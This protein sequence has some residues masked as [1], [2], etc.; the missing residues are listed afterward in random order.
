M[1]ALDETFCPPLTTSEFAKIRQLAYDT[2]GLDLRAGK[3]TLVAARLGKQ[4]RERGFRSFDE[5]YQHVVQDSTGEGLVRLIDCLTTNHT[6]FF[7]EPA[8]FDFLRKT[9]LP[10]WKHR[11]TIDL[12]SAA[13]STG[14][15]PYSIAMCI[16]D[17]LGASAARKVRILATDISTRVLEAA[18]KGIYPAER[19]ELVSAIQLRAYW[20]RGEG[21]WAGSYRVKKELREMIDFRRMNLLQPGAPGGRYALIFCR[22]VMIYFDRPTQ[23]RV[24]ERLAQ[25][26]EPGGYLLTGHAESL[27]GIGHGLGYI[28]PAVYR[29]PCAFPEKGKR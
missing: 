2:F 10:E 29:K 21:N 27:S 4:I 18:E 12:W 24:V 11:D 7:R 25:Q 28:Q 6:S 22:N 20:L 1:P 17:E 9:F 19:L 3:E 15:E 26:L 14:E 8:H 13:C 5:Y 16:L 23:Q